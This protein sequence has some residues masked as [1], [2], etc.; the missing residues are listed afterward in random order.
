[1][2]RWGSPIEDYPLRDSVDT[3]ITYSGYFE[4][5]RAAIGAGA[6]LSELEKWMG[7]EYDPKFMALVVAWYRADGLIEQHAGDAAARKRKR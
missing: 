5:V 1:M 4:G 7:G 6:T 2:R 3:G